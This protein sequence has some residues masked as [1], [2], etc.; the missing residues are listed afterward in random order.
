MHAPLFKK[1]T[2]L[3]SYCQERIKYQSQMSHDRLTEQRGLMGLNRKWGLGSATWARKGMTFCKSH[4]FFICN[5]REIATKYM[6]TSNV[7]LLFLV[8]SGPVY[9]VPLSGVCH[10]KIN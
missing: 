8:N 6:S 7:L 2:L 3:L 10:P 1:E 4:G 5:I 9:H